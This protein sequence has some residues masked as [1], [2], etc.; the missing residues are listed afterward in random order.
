MYVDYMEDQIE[1]KGAENVM[2]NLGTT[3]DPLMVHAKEGEV[4]EKLLR[5]ESDDVF[6]DLPEET[7]VA[8]KKHM[9]KGRQAAPEEMADLAKLLDAEDE[10]FSDDYTK[11]R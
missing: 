10:E 5:G 11:E 4:D 3:E 2:L 9:S 8:I 7:V 1:E 6:A